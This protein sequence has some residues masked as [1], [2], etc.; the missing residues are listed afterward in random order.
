M[1]LRRQPRQDQSPEVGGPQ[2]AQI[3]ARLNCLKL[4]AEKFAYLPEFRAMA[5]VNLNG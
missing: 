1:A 2:L 5:V 4:S 3:S